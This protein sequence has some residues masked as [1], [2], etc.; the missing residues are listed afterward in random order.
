MIIETIIQ[1]LEDKYSHII[2]NYPEKH[3]LLVQNLYTNVGFLVFLERV[4]YNTVFPT[5]DLSDPEL[6]DKLDKIIL[7]S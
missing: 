6:F 4:P 2:V 5:I 3:Y 7:D 1:Y